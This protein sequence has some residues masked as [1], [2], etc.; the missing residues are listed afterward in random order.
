V[1]LHPMTFCADSRFDD[2]GTMN[3]L[4]RVEDVSIAV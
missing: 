3:A 2:Y 1:V 4:G